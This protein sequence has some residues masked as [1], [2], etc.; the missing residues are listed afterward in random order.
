MYKEGLV[1]FATHKYNSTGKG[2]R[3]MF[4]TNY[5]VNKY[6]DKFVENDNAIEDGKGSK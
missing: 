4:L 5:S 1:R 3:F 2:S 6:S